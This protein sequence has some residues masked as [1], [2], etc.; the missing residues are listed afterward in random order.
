MLGAL[1][2][3]LQPTGI[4][5]YCAEVQRERIAKVLKLASLGDLATINTTWSGYMVHE[6]A[7]EI[8]EER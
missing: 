8:N 5:I 6:K 3:G 1:A 4:E 7:H 2:L